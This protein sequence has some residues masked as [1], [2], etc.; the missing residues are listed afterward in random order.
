M[1]SS[2]NDVISTNES[3]WTI[4]GHMIYNLAY[5]QI[6]QMTATRIYL[7][8][9]QVVN[10]IISGQTIRQREYCVAVIDRFF[11]LEKSGHLQSA[12]SEPKTRIVSVNYL[13]N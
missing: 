1:L 10:C 7:F 2:L 8:T 3:T 6:L 5:T 9:N 12:N 13:G 4:A 11:A